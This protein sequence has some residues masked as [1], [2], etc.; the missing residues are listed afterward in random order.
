MG[1]VVS[2]PS[3]DSPRQN[4]P[5]AV[6]LERIS[7]TYGTIAAVRDLSLEVHPGEIYGFL[8]LNGA[9]KTTS[10]RIILDLVRP[11]SG[12][13]CVFGIDCR[14]E[15]LAA[16]ARIGYLP[17]ELGF[18]GDMTGE[19]TLDVLARL[20]GPVVDRARRGELLERMQLASRDLRRKVRDYSTGMKRKLGIVQA[21]QPDPPLLI[22]DEPTEGL[23]PLMQDA[24]YEL[25][26]DTRRRGRTVFMSS[27]VLS[28]VE[29]VCD[30]IGLLR[31]GELVLVSSVSDVRNMAARQ[32]RVSFREDLP[33]GPVTTRDR[34]PE[35]CELIETTTRT[36]TV[37]VRGA[38]GPLLSSL[39][40]FP[41]EDIEVREPHLEEVLKT[42]YKDE[43]SS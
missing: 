29:R 26:N 13:A 39:G 30:R 34:L 9:G 19:A 38:M 2:D 17:G 42:Y 3:R 11:T 40:A 8:G 27:H 36:W 37:R 31:R 35:N 41:V 33:M 24:L 25:L 16:R 21:F 5:P 43:V 1:R 15:S 18:Y 20:N 4:L 28:E 32:I 22:L 14:T 23:D 6:Q 7:K 12:R 10:I